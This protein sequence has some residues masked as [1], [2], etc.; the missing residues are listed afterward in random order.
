MDRYEEARFQM[1]KERRKVQVKVEND[2]RKQIVE[3]ECP[4][5]VPN[6]RVFLFGQKDAEVRLEKNV[7]RQLRGET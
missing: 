2:R 5:L 3:D 1:K 4:I 7:R 6:K